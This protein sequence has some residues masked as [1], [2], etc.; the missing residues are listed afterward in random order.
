MARQETANTL[1]NRVAVEVG[2]PAASDPLASTDEAFI[3]LAGLLT[4]C[5][6]ELVELNAW[7]VLRNKIDFTTSDG[8]LDTQLGDGVTVGVGGVYD[9]PA[10]FSY[11]FDQTGWDQTNDWR[12][13]GPVSAQ[14]WA[15]LTANTTDPIV[16]Q[17]RQAD[18]KLEVYPQPISTG[19]NITFEY[20]SRYWVK[21]VGQSAA[22]TDVISTGTDVVLYEPILVQKFLKVKFLEAKGFDS[23]IA[24]REFENIFLGRTGRDTGAPILSTSGTRG[25]IHYLD[26]GNVRDTGYGS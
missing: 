24:R 20:I 12:L 11:M 18:N 10:D 26:G 14:C 7:Q 4:T 21:E 15:E 17:F 6:Q 13:G 25:G 23:T 19:Q 9:L 5:G 22:N 8:S 16:V 1:I 3:Q 2:L